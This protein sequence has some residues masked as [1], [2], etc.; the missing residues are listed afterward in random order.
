M[1]CLKTFSC[2]W[3]RSSSLCSG[4]LSNLFSGPSVS[5]AWLGERLLGSALRRIFTFSFRS[6]RVPRPLP[7]FWSLCWRFK[8]NLEERLLDIFYHSALCLEA[9]FALFSTEW[10]IVLTRHAALCELG[11]PGV[12]ITG[13]CWE[14][15]KGNQN[16]LSFLYL[17]RCP[18]AVLGTVPSGRR[19]FLFSLF[20]V[21]LQVFTGIFMAEMCLKIIALDPYGYFRRGWNV[22]DSI[23][24]LLSFADVMNSLVVGKQS[25]LFFHSLRVVR[26]FL[27]C[28]TEMP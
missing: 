15:R 18:R 10:G 11:N 26:R 27:F 1:S 22:F 4:P 23:V 12:G 7:S 3:Q 8:G 20:P 28:F 16:A 24:A 13:R 19:S 5:L 17:L 14:R 25:P 9:N 2:S 6:C 21:S